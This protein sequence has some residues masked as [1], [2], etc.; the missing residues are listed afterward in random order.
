MDTIA[1]IIFTAF[2]NIIITS[3]VSNLIFYRY[4]KKI[5]ATIQ[6]SLFE[7]QIKFSRI[8]PKT[9]EVLETYNQKTLYCSRLSSKFG[10]EIIKAI[11]EKDTF[12]AEEIKTKHD[13]LYGALV[14]FRKYIEDN[15]LHLPNALIEGEM[16]P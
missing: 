16:P 10:D 7:H 9:L 2:A 5:D 13:E 4:Q 1:I 15:R 14:D 11:S 8:Y 12:Q 3:I 6:K